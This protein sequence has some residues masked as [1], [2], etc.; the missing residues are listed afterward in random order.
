MLQGVRTHKSY[1]IFCQERLPISKDGNHICSPLLFFF[2]LQLWFILF[3][4]KILNLIKNLKM[5]PKEDLLYITPTISLDNFVFVYTT[6]LPPLWYVRSSAGIT[7]KRSHKVFSRTFFF[8]VSDSSLA[9]HSWRWICTYK[10]SGTTEPILKLF[11]LALPVSTLPKR[12]IFTEYK[13]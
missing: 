4:K 2:L 6:L 9:W 13:K 7:L 8:L 5:S 12:T 3:M 10:G 11:K 1:F